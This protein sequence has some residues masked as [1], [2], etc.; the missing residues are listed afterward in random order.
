MPKNVNKKTLFRSIQEKKDRLV[1]ISRLKRM[2]EHDCQ[3]VKAT[4]K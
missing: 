4:Q 2:T 1:I 3:Q